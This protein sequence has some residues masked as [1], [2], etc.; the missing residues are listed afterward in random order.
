QL[1]GSMSSLPEDRAHRATAAMMDA[2]T[3]KTQY[4]QSDLSFIQPYPKQM[5]HRGASTREASNR[6]PHQNDM[7][8]K[9]FTIIL[10]KLN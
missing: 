5:H 4:R 8:L 2:A 1:K 7:C 9:F 10:I 6:Q 3:T